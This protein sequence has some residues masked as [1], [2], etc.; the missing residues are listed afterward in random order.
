[1]LIPC[2]GLKTKGRLAGADIDAAAAWQV[3]TGSDQV[4]VAVID[5]GIDYTHSRL[6]DNIWR[7]SGEVAGDGVDNDGN[8]F[9]DDIHGVDFYDDDSDPFD[10]VSHG[11]HVAGTVL[12]VAPGVLVMPVRFLGP[13]GGRTSDAIRALDYAVANGAHISNNSWGSRNSPS[14]SLKDAIARASEANHI[15]VAAAGNAGLDIDTH[16]YAPGGVD[17][18][19]VITVAA[20]D[21]N[22]QLAWFS[23]YGA[24]TVLKL[25]KVVGVHSGGLHLFQ[26]RRPN[27]NQIKGLA[28]FDGQLAVAPG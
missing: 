19:N 22:D 25:M 21:H 26:L 5:T 8:G 18:V 2:G 14:R 13:D 4:I 6:R 23:N 27:C 24:E 28:K 16:A 15:F 20:T 7:N 17:A 1:M 11:T 3:T 12:D 10:G 9:V